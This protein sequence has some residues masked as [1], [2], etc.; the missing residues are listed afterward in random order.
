MPTCKIC[1]KTLKNPNSD[2]HINSKFHQ[3]KLNSSPSAKA[4]DLSSQNVIE[5]RNFIELKNSILN[6]EK[7]MRN[8]EKQI[9][10][11]RVNSGVKIKKTSEIKARNIQKLEK[12]IVKL[13]K[14]RSSTQQIKGNIPLKD[15]K[16][17]LIKRYNINEK[18]FEE[19]I[20]KLYRKQIFDLQPGGSPLDYQLLSPTGKKFYYLLVKR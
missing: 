13:I 20:L 15:L 12:D 5:T 10:S 1:G 14:Q 2:S 4:L 19:I 16:E 9:Q 3:A 6:L 18:D 7:R 11:I 17:I 8:V